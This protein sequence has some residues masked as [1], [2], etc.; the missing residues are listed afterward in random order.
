MWGSAI[1]I[2]GFFVIVNV[3]GCLGLTYIHIERN[4]GT[5]RGKAE[6]ESATP[7]LSASSTVSI[8]DTLTSPSTK[9]VASSRPGFLLASTR[10]LGRLA[11]KHSAAQNAAASPLGALSKSSAIVTAAGTTT[12][13]ASAASASS[14]LPFETM[15]VTWKGIGYTVNLPKA[16]GGG[17]K[18]LLRGISGAATPGRLLA[19]MGAS[20]AGKTTLLDV[21]AVSV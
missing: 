18:V 16:G 19:L 7:L 15:S 1:F 10:W 3:L 21:I 12:A 14:V 17:T 8:P 20:G 5:A 2:I 13:A 11:S 6:D 4:I 9:Q